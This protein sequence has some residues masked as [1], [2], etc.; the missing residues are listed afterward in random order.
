MRYPA[1][2]EPNTMMNADNG[3]HYLL[4]GVAVAARAMPVEAAMSE[5]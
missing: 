3:K 1:V 4:P 2:I 5:F